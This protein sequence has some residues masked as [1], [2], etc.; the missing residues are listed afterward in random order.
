M[1]KRPHAQAGKVRFGGLQTPSGYLFELT[2]GRLCLDLANTVDE[3]PT[4]HPRPLLLQYQDALDWASQAG[5]L[6]RTEAARLREHAAGHQDA[7]ARA[8]RRLTDA[9]E[10]IFQIF[11]AI[12]RARPIPA[13]A[14][15]TLNALIPEVFSKRCLERHG[16]RFVWAWRATETPDLD[17]PLS[18][19]VWSATELLTSPELDRVRQC[20]GAGCAWLFL[21][22]SKSRTR[23]WCDMSVCG[24]RAKARRFQARVRS[25]PLG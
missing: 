2:G 19:A 6:S 24:N 16:S 4:E 25:Q 13:P 3:R 5:A 15:R 9:R 22:T 18:A 21:D 12:A 1:T 7:A 23:R 11:S 17:C 14:L 8:L 20:E 10:G